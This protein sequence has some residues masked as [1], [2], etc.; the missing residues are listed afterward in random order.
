[1]TFSLAAAN[2]F[3]FV[4]GGLA[5]LLMAIRSR[6]EEENLIARFGDDYRRYRERTGRFVP[7]LSRRSDS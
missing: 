5:I 4:S 3:I 6:K 7:R 2:W 1:M